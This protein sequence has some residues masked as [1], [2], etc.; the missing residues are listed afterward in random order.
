M[1]LGFVAA[2]VKIQKQGG[3][4][5]F[6]GLVEQVQASYDEGNGVRYALAAPSLAVA[7]TKFRFLHGVPRFVGARIAFSSVQVES[8]SCTIK[9]LGV[10]KL[11]GAVLAAPRETR[12]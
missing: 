5:F 3:S 7:L 11:F 4:A 9:N 2:A 8:E 10:E 1:V 6:E 12:G